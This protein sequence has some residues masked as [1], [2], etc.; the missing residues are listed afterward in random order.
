MTDI[1]LLALDLDGTLLNADKKISKRNR[2][3]IFAARAKGVKVVLTTGRPLKAME[4]LLDEL[5]T[6]VGA[7][8]FRPNFG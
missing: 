5:G 2:E 8:Q 3:A 7:T 6:A 4:Y 1:K